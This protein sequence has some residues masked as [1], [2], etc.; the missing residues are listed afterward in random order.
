MAAVYADTAERRER[1]MARAVAEG[2]VARRESDRVWTVTSGSRAG[3]TYAVTVGADNRPSAC[4]CPAGQGGDPVCKHRTLVGAAIE[5]AGAPTRED[6][7]RLA[8]E[9]RAARKCLNYLGA[10]VEF[11]MAEADAFRN[12]RRRID[13]VGAALAAFSA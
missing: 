1:A 13:E 8:D 12:A 2:L 7:A 6:F 3:Q 9:L 4:S 5:G 11:D 10:W